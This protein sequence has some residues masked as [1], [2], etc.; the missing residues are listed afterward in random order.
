MT[1]IGADLKLVFPIRWADTARGS[2][3]PLI[4]AY[5]TPISRDVF[6]LNYRAISAANLTIFSK[7]VGFAAESGPIIATLALRDAARGDALESLES[8]GDPATPLLG[9]IKRL[10]MVL[11]PS[12]QGYDIVPVDIALSRGTIDAEDWKEAESSIVFFTCGLWMV[13]RER[14]E[15]KRSA[16]ASVLQGSI[17]SLPPTEFVASLATSTKVETF[18]DP[19]PSLVPS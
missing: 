17:T 4:W 1:K 16:L 15:M 6:E 2:I 13:R 19:T 18:A 11:A 8:A 14:R 3:E 10:T 12:P 7:G 5:H 9:E